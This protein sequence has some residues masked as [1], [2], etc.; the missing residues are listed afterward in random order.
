VRLRGFRFTEDVAVSGRSE[1]GFATEKIDATVTVDGPR[2]R[3]RPA[4]R[5]AGARDMS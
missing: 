1:Y 3:G 4:G 2:R 5:A